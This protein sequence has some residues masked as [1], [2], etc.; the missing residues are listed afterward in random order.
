MTKVKEENSTL[1][2]IK[3]HTSLIADLLNGN[4]L[5]RE[6]FLDHLPYVLFL[7][8]LALAYI[9]N[10]FL[11]EQNIRNLNKVNNEIKELRSE[12][13]TLKSELMYK[14][15]QSE[16]A[17]IIEEREMGLLESFEPPKKIVKSE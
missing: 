9:S 4:I 16:L 14:S 1:K 10:G 3:K 15:K 13:I 11:A 8:L 17:K 7:A 12:Y 6:S 5:T 2:G